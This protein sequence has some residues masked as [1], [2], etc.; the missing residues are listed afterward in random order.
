[1]PQFI[2]FR[3]SLLVIDVFQSC[4]CV[5]WITSN[6]SFMRTCFWQKL[7]FCRSWV[8]KIIHFSI[9]QSSTL[10]SVLLAMLKY[11]V[12]DL[13]AVSLSVGNSICKVMSRF[14]LDSFPSHAPSSQNT[15]WLIRK[16]GWSIRRT[17]RV[18]IFYQSFFSYVRTAVILKP[19]FSAF[20]ISLVI[21]R[22]HEMGSIISICWHIHRIN[23]RFPRPG[24]EPRLLMVRHLLIFFENSTVVE[25][26]PMFV[27]VA[28][29]VH[30]CLS[31]GVS[32]GQIA[33]SQ[34]L[35]NQNCF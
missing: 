29:C 15:V 20:T 7:L 30:F 32:P 11:N 22:C 6:C 19:P 16:A 21:S 9:K 18:Q 5:I 17:K 25:T 35:P 2:V 4:F 24:R 34:G 8:V 14:M 3:T 28:M 33:R 12:V 13:S 31:P 26:Y 10:V 23:I 27:P 1:M